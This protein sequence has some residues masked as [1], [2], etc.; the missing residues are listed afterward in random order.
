[1]TPGHAARARRSLAALERPGVRDRDLHGQAVLPGLARLPSGR[2]RPLGRRHR[3]CGAPASWLAEKKLRRPLPGAPNVGCGVP[4]K[5]LRFE[6]L[7]ASE[8][9]PSYRSTL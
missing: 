7:G 8:V 3:G 1:M 4:A 6:H 9:F 5:P 2:S